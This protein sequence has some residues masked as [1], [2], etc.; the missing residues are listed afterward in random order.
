MIIF[1]FEINL[2]LWLVLGRKQTSFGFQFKTF[3]LWSGRDSLRLCSG[4]TSRPLSSLCH[5]QLALPF[6]SAR[7]ELVEVWPGR[8][9]NPHGQLQPVVF[10]TTAYTIPPPGLKI[11]I[12]FKF[13]LLKKFPL[14]A[15]YYF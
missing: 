12:K 3:P 2:D 13:K 14:F 9:S 5:T 1:A 6:V 4:L 8:D 7:T 15:W 11:Y 10:E